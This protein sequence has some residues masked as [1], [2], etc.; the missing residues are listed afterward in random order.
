MRLPCRDSRLSKLVLALGAV[1]TAL[2]DVQKRDVVEMKL[3][4]IATAAAL[5]FATLSAPAIAMDGDPEKGKKV[6]RK[7][8]ACHKMEEGKNGVGPSLYN[9]VGREAGS[10]EGFKY[11]SA[12]AESG[13][14]WDVETMTTFLKK[15]KDLVPGT[16]MAFAGLKKD[17]QIA[18]VIA[19]LSA[20]GE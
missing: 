6:F 5:G 20:P 14:T 2:G 13:L 12:M 10:I 8:K 19:Y 18:D 3:T 11:S 9:I 1:A 4:Q 17:K 7:C 16:K 15:P